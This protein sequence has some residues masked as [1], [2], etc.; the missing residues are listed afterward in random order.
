MSPLLSY[1]LFIWK[2][3]AN[4]SIVPNLWFDH[5]LVPE[6]SIVEVEVI[7]Q[8]SH[9]TVRQVLNTHE[10]EDAHKSSNSILTRKPMPS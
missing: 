6:L 10:L 5:L 8:V 4:G 3:N 7:E 9:E 1:Y 2:N